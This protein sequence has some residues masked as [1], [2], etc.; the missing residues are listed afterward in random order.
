MT[1][2]P[3]EKCAKIVLPLGEIYIPL[4]DLIDIE[5]ERLRLAKERQNALSE[6]ERS[7]KM[8]A[9]PGFISK[10]PAQLVEAE[11][12]KIIVNKELLAKID[13]AIEE[14]S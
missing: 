12:Q 3:K 5:K 8:L 7:E 14:Y 2:Q 6:L 1:E 9:N 10:A 13:K 11:R 4:G